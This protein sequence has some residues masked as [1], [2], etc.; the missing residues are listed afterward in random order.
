MQEDNEMKLMAIRIPRLTTD[1]FLLHVC[2]SQATH[3][4]YHQL[5]TMNYQL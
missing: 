3:V 5:S 1:P 2:L 4:L